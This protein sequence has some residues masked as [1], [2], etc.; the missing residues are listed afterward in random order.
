MLA[1]SSS[2]RT[3][4]TPDGAI[5]L[6]VERGQM[7]CVNPIGSQILELLAT[8]SDEAQIAAHLSASYGV[9]IDTV[10][11]DVRDFLQTLNQQ[12]ILTQ[13]SPAATSGQEE[14]HGNRDTT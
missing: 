12:R 3:T 7:F 6:D 13:G 5:L 8:G 10:R 4:R 11:V 2:V 1:I 9:D 14:R